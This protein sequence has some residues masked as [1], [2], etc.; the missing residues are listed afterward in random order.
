MVRIRTLF[1]E[2]DYDNKKSIDVEKA[3]KFNQYVDRKISGFI[4]DKDAGDFIMYAALIDGE[5]V[6]YEEW[7]YNWAKLYAS[8]KNVYV[9]FFKEYEEILKDSPESFKEMMNQDETF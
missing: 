6:G 2:I 9:K 1:E 4:A 7:V 3:C 5:N 8:E